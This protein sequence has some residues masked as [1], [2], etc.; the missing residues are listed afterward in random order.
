MRS[1]LRRTWPS[2]HAGTT[3]RHFCLPRSRHART[4]LSVLLFTVHLLPVLSLLFRY[5]PC[6]SQPFPAIPSCHSP[7]IRSTRL[8]SARNLCSPLLPCSATLS[9]THPSPTQLRLS[10]PVLPSSYFPVSAMHILAPPIRSSHATLSGPVLSEPNHANTRYSIPAI[11]FRSPHRQCR[12]I[13]ASNP[14]AQ[15]GTFQ[16][17]RISRA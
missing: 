15:P 7:L 3:N 6:S 10:D 1:L 12:L 11:S 16:G 4:S 13:R 14:F 5:T 8:R 17:C 2:C 9:Q